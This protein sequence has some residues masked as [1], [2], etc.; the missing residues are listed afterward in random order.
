MT[1]K[2]KYGYLMELAKR[3]L[4]EH[5]IMVNFFKGLFEK[6]EECKCPQCE[7]LREVVK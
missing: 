1:E 4:K 3:S 7:I 2:E 5:Q 6:P